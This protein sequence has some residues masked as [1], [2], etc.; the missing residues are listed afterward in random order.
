MAKSARTIYVL[1]G[2][3]LNLLGTREPHIYGR[4]SLKDVEKLCRKTAD[5]HRRIGL[6]R[7]HRVPICVGI[8]CN[9]AIAETA[10][11]THD[12]QCDLAAIGYQDLVEHVVLN[13][14]IAS[15]ERQECKT[16]RTSPFAITQ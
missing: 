14:R 8:Y 7:M 4:S 10:C 15:S 2:P 12:A 1:N 3:N 13:G 9:D 5:A 16:I 11:G 6:A